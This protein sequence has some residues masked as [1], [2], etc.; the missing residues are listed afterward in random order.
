MQF[1]APKGKLAGLLAKERTSRPTKCGSFTATV[2][3]RNTERDAYQS[4]DLK[5]LPMSGTRRDDASPKS[6]ARRTSQIIQKAERHGGT[7]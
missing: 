5:D 7:R 2:A 4:L 3:F 1:I 6:V